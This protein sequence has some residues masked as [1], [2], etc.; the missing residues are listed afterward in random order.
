MG[1]HDV[2]VVLGENSKETMT[3][4]KIHK[5]LVA[6]G[7]NLSHGTVTNNLSKLIKTGFIIRYYP[8]GWRRP[9]YVLKEKATEKML[10]LQNQ[11]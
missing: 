9:E 7:F 10:N 3:S 5:L 4:K 6:K 2:M 11:Y 1:Q 8:S